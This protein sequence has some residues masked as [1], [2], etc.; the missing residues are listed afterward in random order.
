MDARKANRV[1]RGP[2]GQ[3]PPVRNRHRL[4]ATVGHLNHQDNFSVTAGDC[5]AAKEQLRISPDEG[6]R[7][8]LSVS[9]GVLKG[10]PL[11]VPLLPSFYRGSNVAWKYYAHK[12]TLFT[13]PKAPRNVRLKGTPLAR[14]VPLQLP[15]LARAVVL[16][17]CAFLYV[18]VRV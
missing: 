12:Y 1:G 8:R 18:S 2:R 13:S 11:L 17:L 16:A 9:V 3:P 14:L 4:T 7:K 15:P 10:I 6:N 5:D